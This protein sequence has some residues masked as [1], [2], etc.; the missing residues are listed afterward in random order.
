[1]KKTHSP[2]INRR[3]L[4]QGAAAAAGAALLPG[5]VP[6]QTPRKGGVLRVAMPYNPASIDPMTGPEFAGLQRALRRL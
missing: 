1:M 4:V 5:A 6:A 3:T 2:H